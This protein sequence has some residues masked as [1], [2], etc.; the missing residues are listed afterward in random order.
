MTLASL[1]K[2]R[3]SLLRFSMLFFNIF[4]ATGRASEVRGSVYTPS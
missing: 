2:R 4:T 1:M 3:Q